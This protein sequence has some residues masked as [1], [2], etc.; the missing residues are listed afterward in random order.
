M[1]LTG[2]MGSHERAGTAQYERAGLYKKSN[3]HT[4]D[5]KLNSK[6]QRIDRQYKEAIQSAAGTDLLLQ[7]EQGFLEAE[8]DME[9]TFKFKQDEIADAVDSSTANKKFELKLPEFGP[10][11]I[12]YSRTGRDLL[13]GG[14]KGHVASIDWRKGKLGCE[15]HL[16]ELSLIHI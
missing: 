12:D 5:K 3:R 13:L 1:A 16:N 4:K 15:L 6:L 2:K 9:K 7:E 8:N 11:T 14:K 10:Y